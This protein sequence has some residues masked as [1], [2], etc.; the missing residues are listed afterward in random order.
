MTTLQDVM[1]TK[2]QPAKFSAD[3]NVG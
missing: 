3:Y 2:P 1:Q